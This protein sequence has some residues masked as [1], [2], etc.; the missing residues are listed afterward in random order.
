MIRWGHRWC[1]RLS[2]SVGGEDLSVGVCTEFDASECREGR[3]S[4]LTRCVFL[5]LIGRKNIW[6]SFGRGFTV[7]TSYERMC[8]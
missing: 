7:W 4:V 8:V 5:L 1:F 6:G 3:T 2:K